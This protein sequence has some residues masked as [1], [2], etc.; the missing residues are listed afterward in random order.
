VGNFQVCD[1][2][3]VVNGQAAYT[4]QVGSANVIPESANHMIVSLNGVI[5]KPGSSFTVSGSTITF[6]S[7]LVT[8]DAIDFVQILGNVLDIGTPS[9][10]TV[11]TA[12]LAGAL[13]TPST[14]DV[15]GNELILD[16]DA[17]TSIT[18]DT[19]DQITLKTGGTNAV[20]VDSSANL[21]FNSGYGSVQTAYGC[22]AWVKFNGQGTLAVNGSGGVSS[23]TDN[24]TGN[25]DVNFSVTLPEHYQVSAGHKRTGTAAEIVNIYGFNTTRIDIEFWA[26][27][28]LADPDYI[29]IAI[30]R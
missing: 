15:N 24:G 19:D 12:K 29:G 16:A 9:D 3:S 28:S 13:V 30:H 7:N 6:A 17:D 10:A 5:Q 26:N 4:L 20:I 18:A 23:V 21:K 25:Y 22:R 2:I 1:A 11:T 8:G 14:L 27:G